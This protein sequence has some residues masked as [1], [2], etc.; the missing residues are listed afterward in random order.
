M[1]FN[2]YLSLFLSICMFLLLILILSSV[3]ILFG[4]FQYLSLICI[5]VFYFISRLFYGY[6]RNDEF[7]KNNKNHTSDKKGENYIIKGERDKEKA[8]DKTIELLSKTV[9]K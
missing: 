2:K 6:L 1:I 8:I 9:R 4:S 3:I 7:Y 5:V